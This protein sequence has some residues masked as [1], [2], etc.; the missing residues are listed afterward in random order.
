M[1][2]RAALVLLEEYLARTGGPALPVIARVALKTCP[3]K[4]CPQGRI[5]SSAGHA[6]CSTCAQEYYESLNRDSS[7]VGAGWAARAILV[8]QDMQGPETLPMDH[9]EELDQAIELLDY[10]QQREGLWS[11]LLLELQEFQE[12]TWE[13]FRAHCHDITRESYLQSGGTT[14]DTS[15]AL[16]HALVETEVPTREDLHLRA[17]TVA[18]AHHSTDRMWALCQVEEGFVR[19]Y[20]RRHPRKL[21]LHMNTSDLTPEE[22]ELL[23][24]LYPLDTGGS[25][26]E[27]RLLFEQARAAAQL[28]QDAT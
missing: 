6:W 23:I 5:L 18:T 15:L 22:T 1:D 9:W 14:W 19:H 10:H 3:Q 26:R 21:R 28:L 12:K 11:T 20:Q 27:L 7:W 24:G 13:N 17:T 16:V 8:H 25:P 2:I 4:A